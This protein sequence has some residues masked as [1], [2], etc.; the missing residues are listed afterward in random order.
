MF[1]RF[2]PNVNVFSARLNP[3]KISNKKI[4]YSSRN[5]VCS[6]AHR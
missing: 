2:P 4:R 5:A 6:S 1:K 3:Q